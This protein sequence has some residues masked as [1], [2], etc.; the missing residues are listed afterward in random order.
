MLTWDF[1]FRI[2]AIGGDGTVGQVLN[3]LLNKTQ[4]EEDVDLHSGFSPAK[5][6]LPLG[7]IPTGQC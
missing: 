1:Y 3:G 5:G 2:V 6:L 4:Q 7:I